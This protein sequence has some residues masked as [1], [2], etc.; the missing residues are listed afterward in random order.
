MAPS[1]LQQRRTHNTLLFQKLLNLRD[2]ASPFTLVL[3]S[4]AQSGRAVV[5]EF[6]RRALIS[7]SKVIFISFSTLQK[8]LHFTPD[9]FIPAHSKSLSQLRRE[10][11]SHLPSPT[12]PPSASQQKIL[13]IIDN[14]YPLTTHPD[15]LSPFLSSLI[16]HPTISLLCTHH[17]DI[18]LPPSSTNTNPYTPSPLTTLLFLATAIIEPHNFSHELARKRARDKSAREPEFGIA[19]GKEGVIMGFANGTTADTKHGEIVL[20]LELRRKSGRGIRETFIYTPPPHFTASPTTKDLGTIQLL[21]EHASFAAPEIS[22]HLSAQNDGKGDGDEGLE[23]DV[24][25]NLGLTEKQKRDRENVVLPYFDAQKEG[26]IGS[27]GKI[28]Y[29]MGTEDR[30]DFDDEEDEI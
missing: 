8:R 6:W 21:D 12:T 30:E 17:L 15:H 28:L 27:G 18:P 25:F 7:K 29:E 3:D 23:G 19:E 26:G 14:L 10:I 4:L 5:G 24:T 13:L 1:P 11:V 16:I 20:T 22:D 9:V 2:G